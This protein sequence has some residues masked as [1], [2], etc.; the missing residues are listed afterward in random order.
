MRWRQ[1]PFSYDAMDQMIMLRSWIFWAL[2]VFPSFA[3]GQL[4]GSDSL[5]LAELKQ[6]IWEHE[7]RADS[8]ADEVIKFIDNVRGVS[9]DAHILGVMLLSGINTERVNRYLFSNLQL[10]FL[11]PGFLPDMP[12][13]S[14]LST[15]NRFTEHLFEF[16]GKTRLTR[17][18]LQYF[19]LHLRSFMSKEQVLLL[20]NNIIESTDD[21]IT[22]ENYTAL[23]TFVSRLLMDH[24]ILCFGMNNE[25]AYGIIMTIK[26][27]AGTNRR[28]Q[29]DSEINVRLNKIS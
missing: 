17:D 22:K 6:V 16:S 8:L 28:S 21:S 26:P 24:G 2:V 29:N 12:Y 25:K 27:W 7:M 4:S 5:R 9:S 18:Q 19:G 11:N 14:V 15:N 3:L 1:V 23:H 20:V 10:D 13:L